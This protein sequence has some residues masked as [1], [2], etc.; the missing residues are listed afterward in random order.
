MSDPNH[1][2]LDL[3]QVGHEG[4]ILAE[5]QRILEVNLQ[6]LR[7]SSFKTKKQNKIK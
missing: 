3:P 2:T 1:V 5:P 4:E 7:N 6:H